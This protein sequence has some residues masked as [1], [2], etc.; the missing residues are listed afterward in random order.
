LKRIITTADQD[1]SIFES[2][3]RPFF[4][5]ATVSSLFYMTLWT[6]FYTFK[7]RL[8]FENISP[9]MWHAHE[10][11]FGYA[12]AV[13]AGFMLTIEK[14]RFGAVISKKSALIILVVLWILARVFISLTLITDISWKIG[15]ILD[16]LFVLILTIRIS[17]P[18]IRGKD[19]EK[20]GLAAHLALI[21]VSNVVFYLGVLGVL[22][23]GQRL[24]V[25]SALF[26]VI[27]IILLMGRMMIP[28]FIR[29]GLDFK[30]EPRNWRAVDILSLLFFVS[31][32]ILELF[33]TSVKLVSIVSGILALVYSVRLYGWYSNRI[34]G[35]PMLWVLFTAYAWIAVGFGLIFLSLFF[36]IPEL[37]ALHSF[38]Y[39][40][41]GMMTVGFMSRVTLGHTGRNVFA[42]PKV[43][44]SIFTV[45]LAGAVVRVFF[46]I[47]DS[48]NYL[49]WIAVSQILWI[50]S[51]LI[52]AIVFLPMLWNPRIETGV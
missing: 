30:F 48:G 36:N 51:F 35:K 14:Y 22:P 10:M 8:N 32:F 20:T 3:Y 9:T 34:W 16:C 17:Y 13:L 1:F 45:L 29:S 47:I 21:A 49:L 11:L 40:G 12:I 4:I 41:I 38:T 27:S 44:F 23:D 28:L 2:A 19:R 31:F 15:A 25:Y 18:I 46:P 52:F 37:P 42:P 6:A 50:L 24:G 5:L 7:L 39:G 26:L 33:F 43:V